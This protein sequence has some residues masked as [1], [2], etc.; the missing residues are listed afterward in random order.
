[1]HLPSATNFTNQ[2][3]KVIPIEKSRNSGQEAFWP[4]LVQLRII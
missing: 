2:H 1:M 4:W 3:E